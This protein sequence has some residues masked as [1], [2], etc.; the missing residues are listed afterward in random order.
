MALT[1]IKSG[2]LDSAAI[3]SD[4]QSNTVA[5]SNAGDSFTSTDAIN[6]TL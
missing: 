5:G 1:T 2:A 6:N 4:A 3:A